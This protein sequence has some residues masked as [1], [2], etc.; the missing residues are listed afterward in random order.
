MEELISRCRL[1]GYR[2]LIACITQDNDG[3]IHLH[4]A[5]GFRKV[6]HFEKVGEKFGLQLNVEDFELFL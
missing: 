5:L 2:A 4:E 1:G 6:S 3:S